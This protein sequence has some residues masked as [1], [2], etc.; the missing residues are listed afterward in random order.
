MHIQSHACFPAMSV[1]QPLV[2][3]PAC[4]PGEAR[5]SQPPLAR[6]SALLPPPHPAPVPPPFCRES[7]RGVGR[8]TAVAGGGQGFCQGMVQGGL[9]AGGAEAVVGP[10][11]TAQGDWGV[12]LGPERWGSL[13]C[14]GHCVL[15]CVLVPSARKVPKLYCSVRSKP[16]CQ[17]ACTISTPRHTFG[18]RACSFHVQHCC[19]KGGRRQ[20]MRGGGPHPPNW[21]GC[22][23]WTLPGLERGPSTFS[24]SVS[25]LDMV[26]LQALPAPLPYPLIRATGPGT[27]QSTRP[28]CMCAPR[29]YAV[30]SLHTHGDMHRLSCVSTHKF[31][32]PSGAP[33]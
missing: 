24:V 30:P 1:N 31:C 2:S 18:A 27:T 16:Q 6:T 8:R 20:D 3:S 23:I 29:V 9:R 22:L 32:T 12:G 33:K 4:P 17:K 13:S 15:C 7:A 19:A 11:V 28:V 5:S 10:G 26:G 25:R 21:R 14:R